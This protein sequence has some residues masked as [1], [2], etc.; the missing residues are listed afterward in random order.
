MSET[1]FEILEKQ[2]NQ[3]LDETIPTHAAYNINPALEL[4][5]IMEIKGFSFQLNDLCPKK[6]TES[7]WCATFLKDGENFSAEYPQAPVAI[8]AAAIGALTDR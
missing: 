2:L 8:C 5:K 3:L 6:L 1:I 4:V 7:L